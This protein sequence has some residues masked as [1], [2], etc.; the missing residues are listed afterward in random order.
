MHE[1]KPSEV[2]EERSSE[3]QPEKSARYTVRIPGFTANTT[4]VGLGDVIKRATALM[5]VRSC[6][7][8]LGRA[9]KLNEW[10]TFS[11]HR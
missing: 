9:A 7:P 4:D 5:G 6:T 1:E 8:C 10:I 2:S 11:G 3:P